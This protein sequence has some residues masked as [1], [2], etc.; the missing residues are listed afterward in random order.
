MCRRAERPSLEQA[1]LQGCGEDG[2]QDVN[3]EESRAG[4]ERSELYSLRA[5]ECPLRN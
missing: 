3:P 2:G 4:E 1:G 5:E